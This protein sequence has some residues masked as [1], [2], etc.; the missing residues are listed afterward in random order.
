MSPVFHTMLEAI[1]S[2]FFHEQVVLY[3]T[4]VIPDLYFTPL[5]TSPQICILYI[6]KYAINAWTI[7]NSNFCLLSLT[8]YF[9]TM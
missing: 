4:Q 2:W 3:Q 1:D 5:V 7:N 8:F 9:F 6:C